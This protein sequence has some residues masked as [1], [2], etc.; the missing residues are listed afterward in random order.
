MSVGVEGVLD[1]SVGV[2]GGGSVESLEIS[3]SGV[4][5]RFNVFVFCGRK[6]GSMSDQSVT[7]GLI[8][9]S[10]RC[11][12]AKCSMSDVDV[13]GHGQLTKFA[14]YTADIARLTLRVTVTLIG[15]RFGSIV[16]HLRETTNCEPINIDVAS[17]KIN[18][19]RSS[20]L[21]D[22]KSC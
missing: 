22:A 12:P 17:L 20:P 11:L 21:R 9:L 19:R 13:E 3:F 7:W 4:F 15:L 5:F 10:G 18:R 14:Q 8:G 2:Q 6:V 16:I 1:R